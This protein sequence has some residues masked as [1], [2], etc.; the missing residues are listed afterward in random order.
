MST[1]CSEQDVHKIKRA[2]YSEDVSLNFVRMERFSYHL[3]HNFVAVSVAETESRQKNFDWYKKNFTR[4]L[5]NICFSV[6][7][8]KADLAVIPKWNTLE[9]VSLN[10]VRMERFSYHLQ[11]NFVAVSVAETESRQK[12]FDWYKKNFTRLLINICFSV[13]IKKAD[14]AVIP[15][16]NTLER[17]KSEKHVLWSKVLGPVFYA[18]QI[19][20]VP[21]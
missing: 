11:H 9:D 15:K 13:K 20:F 14:L 5:I 3:Q 7:I 2:R 12:N 21:G 17:N 6:K 18:G 8:K 4:L 16:W 1:Y 10:F 19:L